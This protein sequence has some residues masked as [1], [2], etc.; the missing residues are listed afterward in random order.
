ML[1]LQL[2]NNLSKTEISPSHL[3][4]NDPYMKVPLIF[5]FHQLWVKWVCMHIGDSSG[6]IGQTH[7]QFP[8]CLW[9]FATE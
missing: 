7:S 4:N 8:K 1:I 2:K 5:W 9:M 3:K 6:Y